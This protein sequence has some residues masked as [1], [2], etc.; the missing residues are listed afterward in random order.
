MEN[1][2]EKINKFMEEERHYEIFEIAKKN[3]ELKGQIASAVKEF[4][5]LMTFFATNQSIH[6]TNLLDSVSRLLDLMA[7]KFG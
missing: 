6:F 7:M 5:T 3:V 1:A 4:E 2:I